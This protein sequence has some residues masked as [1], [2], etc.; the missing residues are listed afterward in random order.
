MARMNTVLHGRS[1]PR[2]ADV[3]GERDRPKLP[4]S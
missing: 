3:R 1:A 2:H 4:I